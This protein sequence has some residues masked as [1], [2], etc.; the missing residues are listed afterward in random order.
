MSNA[1]I[2]K[3]HSSI[4]TKRYGDKD[5]RFQRDP[6]LFFPHCHYSLTEEGEEGQNGASAKRT[7]MLPYQTFISTLSASLIDGTEGGGQG[8]RMERGSEYMQRWTHV[9]EDKAVLQKLVR[10]S[11]RERGEMRD[12]KE[13]EEVTSSSSP[14]SST[15]TKRKG[16]T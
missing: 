13:G 8:R 14:K 12:R 5:G 2:T 6:S 11:V 9:V 15:T 7:T 10:A 1:T 3:A 4:N 16:T